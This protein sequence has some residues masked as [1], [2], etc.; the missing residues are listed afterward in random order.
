MTMTSQQQR[1]A[2]VMD[3][4]TSKQHHTQEARTVVKLRGAMGR[5]VEGGNGWGA[6]SLL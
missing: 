5:K 6:R 1:D 4:C 3:G 2:F